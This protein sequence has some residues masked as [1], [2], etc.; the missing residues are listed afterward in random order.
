MVVGTIDGVSMEEKQQLS[1]QGFPLGI[2][3]QGDSECKCSFC[4]SCRFGLKVIEHCL[5]IAVENNMTSHFN[6]LV[7]NCDQMFNEAAG[8]FEVERTVH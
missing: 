8:L 1:Y 4:E 2:E 5:T 6:F 3:C 7:F